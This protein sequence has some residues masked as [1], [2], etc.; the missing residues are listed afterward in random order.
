M[1]GRFIPREAI[2][3]SVNSYEIIEENPKDK[4]LPSYLVYAMYNNRAIHILFATDIQGDNIRVVTSYY[5]HQGDW[6][7]D[8]KTMRK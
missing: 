3:G 8:S 5:P 7:A 2:I 6:E 1:T 4:Y